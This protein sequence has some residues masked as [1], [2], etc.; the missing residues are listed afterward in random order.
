MVP[1]GGKGKGESKYCL[2]NKE[3]YCPVASFVHTYIFLCFNN[4]MIFKRTWGSNWS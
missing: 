3:H 1:K 4:D 2:R